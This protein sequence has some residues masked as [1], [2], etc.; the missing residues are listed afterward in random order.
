MTYRVVV[1]LCLDDGKRDVRFVIENV[2]DALG[3]AT[4]VKLTFDDNATGGEGDFFT[5]L[6]V[7][8]PAS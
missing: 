4:G 2:I 5:N 6:G 7:D 3:F 8:I 1:V